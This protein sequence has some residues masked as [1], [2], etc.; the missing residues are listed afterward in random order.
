MNRYK[1]ISNRLEL[2]RGEKFKLVQRPLELGALCLFQ[3][4][5]L[6]VVGRWFP[7]F[8]VQPHRWIDISKTAVKVLGHIIRM[9][10]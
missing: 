6:L 1:V 4:G 2:E 7:G 8:I 5:A 3:I 9:M 10:I